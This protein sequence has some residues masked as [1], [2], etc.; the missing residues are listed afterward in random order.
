MA[1]TSPG[2]MT[3]S[4]KSELLSGGHCF[5]GIVVITANTYST[6]VIDTASTMVG[7][8]I[9]MLVVGPGIPV[10]TYIAAITSGSGFMLSNSATSTVVANSLTVTGDLFKMALIIATPSGTYSAASTNYSNIGG[11]QVSGAGYAA[12]GA[13]LT[14]VSPAMSGITA[15]V[16]FL[17]NPT[18]TSATFSTSGGMIYN[19]SARL[20]GTSGTNTTGA[21]RACSVHDFGGTQTVSNGTFTIL[22]PSPATA[23]TAILRIS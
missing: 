9:G 7:I 12:G 22:L 10:N 19:S 5:L 14:N 6:N 23:T 3:T 2:A 1:I 13:T 21:G 18:W 11:D 16:N 15:W 17:P 20:G 8:A 4:F